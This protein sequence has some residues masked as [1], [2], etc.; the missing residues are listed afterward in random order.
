MINLRIGFRYP[1]TGRMKC[2][3]LVKVYSDQYRFH[4]PIDPAFLTKFVKSLSIFDHILNRNYFF[5][6]FFN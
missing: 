5:V 1:K 2:K 3:G 4:I 6:L